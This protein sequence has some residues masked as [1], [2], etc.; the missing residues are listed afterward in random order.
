MYCTYIVYL[1]CVMELKGPGLFLPFFYTVQNR[2]ADAAK[3]KIHPSS[4]SNPHFSRC[5]M[6]YK[7]CLAP[8]TKYKYV[9]MYIDTCRA[10]CWVFLGNLN[11]H[12]QGE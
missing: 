9:C 7:I 2:T 11:I 4:I 6:Q 10:S 12:F 1:L 8:H 5:C 3:T